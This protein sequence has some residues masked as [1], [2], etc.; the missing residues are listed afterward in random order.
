M[1]LDKT[2]FFWNADY[3][4]LSFTTDHN[5]VQNC[6][7]FGAGDAAV[8]PGAAPETGA[9]AT[10]FYPDAPRANT[11]ITKCDLR[12]SD[13]RLLGLDGQR[14]AHHQQPHLRQRAP[15]SPAT[16]C[17]P[18]G[19]PA[20]R[21]TAPRSTTTSSTR[22]TSTS[23]SKN[24]PVKPLVADADR[25][26][27]SS[28]P[29]MNDAKVHDNWIF[30]NWRDG[31]MLF[32]VPDA[33]TNGGGA[34]GDVFPG[35]SCAGAPAERL[36]T[37]CNNRFYDNKMGQVP[38]G[39]QVPRGGRPV[40]RR[41]QPARSQAR[42][43]NGNDFWWDEFAGNSV[44]LLVRQHGP[45]RQGRQRDRP[46]RGGPHAGVAARTAARLRQR[47]E[48]RV[49]RGPGRSGQDPYLVDCSNGPDKDTGPLDCDWWS[50]A[51][52]AR[53]RGARAR[54][55]RVLAAAARKFNAPRRAC[56]CDT[57]DGR[58][59]GRTSA[60][61][62]SSSP[63]C[64]SLRPAGRLRRRGRAS[65]AQPCPRRRSRWASAPPGRW[66]SSPTAATGTAA[67]AQRRTATVRELRDQLT[68]AEL[69]LERVAAQLDELAYE[70]FQKRCTPRDYAG[71]L[72]RC[73][74]STRASRASPRWGPLAELR[75][76]VRGPDLATGAGAEGLAGPDGSAARV[77]RH[78]RSR[79]G[80]SRRLAH[81]ERA[82]YWPDP[83]PDT[84]VIAGRR[85][86]GSEGAQPVHR[87]AGKAAGQDARGLPGRAC[88]AASACASSSGR[89]ARRAGATPPCRSAAA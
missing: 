1:L 47:H 2:K 50:A 86:R 25:A 32:A 62:R 76:E 57:H 4:H 73:T 77:A 37:S 24:S 26:P 3:G 35:V 40:R 7:G 11:V 58:A 6:D 21:P 64:W 74:S 85:R 89:C 39:L 88:P 30:D 17:R 44:E 45:G 53:Q 83:A 41:A 55:A 80:A 65:R 20:S 36:S 33:L 63:C 22:T 14:R 13:A 23:T 16:R 82:S 43:P 51:A 60:R 52:Q 28:T 75:R 49:Q 70:V 54:A 19:T 79:S 68:A 48:P 84:S 59:V 66:S 46:R 29:G 72:R 12:G 42:M 69:A 38:P 56:G 18:P 15:A 61:R 67:P 10:P 81:I 5:V 87:S 9:Q 34:E 8:Y 78:R 71:S 27:G 31:A